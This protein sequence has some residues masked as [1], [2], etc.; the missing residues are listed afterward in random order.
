MDHYESVHCFALYLVGE[1]LWA[2]VAE[3]LLEKKRQMLNKYQLLLLNDSM[4]RGTP[5]TPVVVSVMI[6]WHISDVMFSY[7]KK[8]YLTNV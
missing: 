6:Q 3:E 2:E 7:Q 8:Y 4:V 1:E 5:C